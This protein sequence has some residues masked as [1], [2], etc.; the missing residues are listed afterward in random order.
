MDGAGSSRAAASSADPRVA[1]EPESQPVPAAGVDPDLVVVYTATSRGFLEPCGCYAK[2]K[3]MGGVAR[4]AAVVDSLRAIGPPVLLVEA[5]DFVGGAGEAG[6]RIGE[7]SLRVF[8]ATGYDAIALG[9]AEL[10]LGEGFLEKAA[11]AGPA[12]LHA[13]WSH[14]AVGP[15]Q[16]DG[17]LIEK[18]GLRVGLI[19]LLDPA[20][21]PPADGLENLVVEPP[22]PAAAAAAA[23]LRE[24]GADVIVVVGH[25]DF[26]TSGR[27]VEEAGSPD[28]WVV[29]HGGKELSRPMARGETL[30]LGPGSGGK[31]L[32]RLDLSLQGDESLRF[33]NELIPLHLD[34]PEKASIAAIVKTLDP[35]VL[36]QPELAET[37]PS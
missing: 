14:P 2:G 20:V 34:L 3:E 11:G 23:R 24:A 8:E 28:L 1:P 15:P 7:V 4:R 17:V 35:A 16:K 10:A 31:L 6:E 5:G 12:L 26:R 19:G 36:H 21:L 25:A 22:A 37:A 27:L 33:A 18:G 9:E 29:G 30:L 13:N 32:G